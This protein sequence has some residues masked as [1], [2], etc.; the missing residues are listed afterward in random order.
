MWPH[1]NLLESFCTKS[2]CKFTKQISI[3]SYIHLILK[4]LLE[5]SDECQFSNIYILFII[6]LGLHKN[7]TSNTQYRYKNVLKEYIKSNTL[8]LNR[9]FKGHQLHKRKSLSLQRFNDSAGNLYFRLQLNT[10][11]DFKSP[12]QR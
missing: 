8:F 12:K 11:P 5:N 1:S 9:W 7:S 10:D 2:I 4:L 6:Q 3:K